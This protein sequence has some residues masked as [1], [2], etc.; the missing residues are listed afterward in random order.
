M[1]AALV[2]YRV[3]QAAKQSDFMQFN[4]TIDQQLYTLDIPEAVLEEAQAFIAEMDSDFDRGL[5]LGRYWIDEPTA[6]QRCQI[7]ANKIVNAL[8]QENVR[9]FYMMAAYI[10]HKFPRLK[11]VTVD[12]NY[13]IDEIDIASE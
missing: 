5:Q 1:D 13:E 7:A 4:I 6:D 3:L 8:H 9:L 10:L 12:S 11:M 2:Y